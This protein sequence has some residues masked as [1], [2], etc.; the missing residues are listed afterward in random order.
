MALLAIRADNAEVPDAEES[1]RKMSLSRKD[2]AAV[3]FAQLQAVKENVASLRSLIESRGTGPEYVDSLRN[4]MDSVENEIYSVRQGHHM[5]FVALSSEEEQLNRAVASMEAEI[6]QWLSSDAEGA[7]SK[8]AG[9]PATA[10]ARLGTSGA[11]YTP[12][13]SKVAAMISQPQLPPEVVAVD[14]I[15][16]EEG[17]STGGWDDGDHER[18]LRYRTMFKGQPHVYCAKTAEDLIDHDVASVERH[19][20]WYER[21]LKLLEEKKAAIRSWRTTKTS[22]T[23]TD[24][25][26]LDSSPSKRPDTAVEGRRRSAGEQMERERQKE[27]IRQW[28]EEKAREAAEAEEKKR[29]ANECFFTCGVS[30][31]VCGQIT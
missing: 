11:Q 14:R 4:T 22:H 5:A 20:L 12:G 19:D 25:T 3:L 31:L 23:L 28:K 9:R 21:Y 10:S 18:F 17:G 26:Q 1:A 27:Q 29:V 15:L 8:G 2:E 30:L 13:K 6:V 24:Q 16:R 7:S